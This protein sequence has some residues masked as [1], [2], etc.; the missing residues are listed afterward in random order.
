MLPED[1]KGG[2]RRLGE[3]A[4]CQGTEHF[5]KGACQQGHMPARQGREAPRTFKRLPFKACGEILMTTHEADSGKAGLEA[6]SQT[7]GVWEQ[8]LEPPGLVMGQGGA[9]GIHF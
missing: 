7:H 3:W 2:A 4:S 8:R 9:K 6:E 5:Y 1:W